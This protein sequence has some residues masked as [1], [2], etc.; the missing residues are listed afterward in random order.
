M[1]GLPSFTQTNCMIFHLPSGT[2]QT[3]TPSVILS[4]RSIRSFVAVSIAMTAISL[5]AADAGLWYTVPPS[6]SSSI[7]SRRFMASDG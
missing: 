2:F 4:V 6:T 5:P 7:L 3:I 1:F